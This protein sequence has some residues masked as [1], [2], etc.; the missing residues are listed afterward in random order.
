MVPT[1][2]EAFGR[3]AD[4]NALLSLEQVQGDATE[5]TEILRTMTAAQAPLLLLHGAAFL[6]VR[7]LM[8]NSHNKVAGPIIC[9]R[10]RFETNKS[11]MG[12]AMLSRRMLL[13]GLLLGAGLCITGCD[14]DGA[15]VVMLDIN[16]LEVHPSIH[17]HHPNLDGSVRIS[18]PDIQTGG[19]Y[20]TTGD[21]TT[22]SLTIGS[23]VTL[24][25]LDSLYSFD[26]NQIIIV[27]PEG[28]DPGDVV[29]DDSDQPG[30]P[31]EY[32]P[33]LP[34]E[35]KWVD[36]SGGKDVFDFVPLR[37]A[38]SVTSAVP[39]PASAFTGLLA[40]SALGMRLTRRRL[41]G[42]GL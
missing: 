10:L 31:G 21:P 34:M 35:L 42:Q 18:N 12:A 5:A 37:V 8:Q 7:N 25:R 1:A 32:E 39:E 22:G 28:M 23:G 40:L 38:P 24:V 3:Q 19:S 30:V 36:T 14:E 26:P 16:G 20:I 17:S 9:D 41:A 15:Q 2:V 13:G 33:V 6:S 11:F 27:E 4:L 29:M